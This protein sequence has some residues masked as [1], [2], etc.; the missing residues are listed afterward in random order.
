MSVVEFTSNT[1]G[2]GGIVEDRLVSG[3]TDNFESVDLLM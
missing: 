1:R 3:Y 2:F